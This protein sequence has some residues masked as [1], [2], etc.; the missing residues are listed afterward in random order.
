MYLKFLFAF[1][2]VFIYYF[3][4]SRMMN[5]LKNTEASGIYWDLGLQM[6]VSRIYR[7]NHLQGFFLQHPE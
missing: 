3:P 2:F 5:R 4:S 6:E 7:K 1:Y